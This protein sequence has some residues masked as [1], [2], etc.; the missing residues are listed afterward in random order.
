MKIKAGCILILISIITPLFAIT[1]HN[2]SPFPLFGAPYYTYSKYAEK[3]S[4]EQELP[5]YGTIS[6]ERPKMRLDFGGRR[7]V[8]GFE[9]QFFTTPKMAIDTYKLL[10]SQDISELMGS[11]F[12]IDFYQNQLHSYSQAG[13][14]LLKPVERNV[15]DPLKAIVATLANKT[16]Q[17]MIAILPYKTMSATVKPIQSLPAE[18][19]SFITKR[20]NI[21]QSALSKITK[22][23]KK[24][25][26]V[27]LC[28]SGGGI[29]AC[30]ATLGSL[31]GL[32]ATDL[33]NTVSYA[34]G[35]SGSTWALGGW[36]QSKKGLDDYLA[37][38]INKLEK[39]LFTADLDFGALSKHLFNKTCFGQPLSIVDIYG[40]LLGQLLIAAPGINPYQQFL[41]NQKDIIAS[42]HYPFPIYTAL[43]TKKNPGSNFYPT[44]ECNPFWTGCKDLNGIIDS[45]ALGRAFDG[46][47]TINL[48]N[49]EPFHFL[50]GIFGYAIGGNYEELLGHAKEKIKPEFLKTLLGKITEETPFGTQ[51]LRPAQVLNPVY[52]L[53]PQTNTRATQQTLT[54]VD[55]GLNFNLPIQPFFE[56][57]GRKIDVLII[58]DNSDYTKDGAPGTEL[59]KAAA[60]CKEQKIPFPDISKYPQLSKQTCTVMEDADPRA[61]I[62]VY[63]PLLNNPNHPRQFDINR[64][65]KEECSTF[66]FKYSGENA[67]DLSDLTYMNILIHQPDIEAAIRKKAGQLK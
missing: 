26:R 6:F 53:N 7:F 56:V 52:K 3:A 43:I 29:R 32:Q 41:W 1:V 31:R 42:G 48:A 38:L 17:A 18:E 67:Q 10:N 55:A 46:G 66:N 44:L 54:L 12:Y 51:R 64:C 58:V 39:G 37:F 49:P 28:F 9:K 23:S 16:Y 60:Y 8:F 59:A 47:K 5:S 4:S 21:T 50:L 20:D 63:L 34:A 15:V 62:V 2:Q 24:S 45:W 57:P 13:W 40:A 14:V 36:I 65:F 22:N 35:L 61:P 19:A 27:G 30:L 11:T 33:L 25:P